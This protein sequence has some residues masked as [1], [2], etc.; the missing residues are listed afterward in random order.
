MTQKTE[1]ADYPHKVQQLSCPWTRKEKNEYHHGDFY[2][3]NQGTDV[4]LHHHLPPPKHSYDPKLLNVPAPYFGREGCDV[5]EWQRYISGMNPP[6]EDYYFGIRETDISGHLKPSVPALDNPMNDIFWGRP[7]TYVTDPSVSPTLTPPA[8]P[9]DG[10][11]THAAMAWPTKSQDDQVPLGKSM[12]KHQSMIRALE[13][14][15]AAGT[16]KQ[17]LVSLTTL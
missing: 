2:Y 6:T 15:Q 10:K 11:G 13:R 16:T 8:R 7:K 9:L 12:S 5:T 14:S 17:S 1:L 4:T 3:G